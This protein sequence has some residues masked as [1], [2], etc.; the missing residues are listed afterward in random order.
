MDADRGTIEVPA[1]PPRHRDRRGAVA[2]FLL[3]VGLAWGAGNVGPVVGELRGE[4][5]ISL[6]AVGLLSGT[7]FYSAMV[8]GIVVAPRLAERV[9]LIRGMVIACLL[10]GVGSLLFALA[11]GFGLL[12]A[13]RILAGVALGFA[14]VLGPVFARATGGVGR[15]GIF[16]A[17]FQLG[18]AGGLGVGSAL[19]DSGVDWRF[20]F[21]VSA[22]IAVSA[23]PLLSAERVQV[24]L[25]G[26]EHGFLRAALRSPRVW[27]LALLFMAMFAVP[28]TLG[29]WFVHYETVDGTLAAGLAGGFAFLLFGVSA[30][31]RQV[32]G[33]L[34]S[35][36]VSPVL[37]AGVTP[38]LAAAGLALIALETSAAAVALAAVLMGAGFALPYAT[39]MTEAQKLY[40]PEPAQPTALLTMVG[41]GV[42]IGVIPLLGIVLDEGQGDAGFL[43]LAAFVVVAGL[44]NLRPVQGEVGTE[45]ARRS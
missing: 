37:L 11:P 41:T 6:T 15:V 10:G 9:G 8:V 5:G 22:A 13:G 45:R 35:R 42:A 20:G 19:A 3:G 31:M 43:A 1:P 17:S 4:F 40:P 21:I 32:G 23:V 27:R 14:G 39:M 34:A 36:G 33:R 26:G 38:L 44:A 2:V 24:E 29:A 16:G 12:A 25:S 28:L 30:L 18:I 7:L